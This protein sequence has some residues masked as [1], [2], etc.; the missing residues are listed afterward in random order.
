[1][2]QVIAAK[3]VGMSQGTYAELEKSGN[4]SSFTVSLAKAYG[5][6]PE[7]LE[8]GRGEMLTSN[9]EDGPSIRGDVPL[10]SWVQA[11]YG[12]SAVDNLQ[13]GEGERVETTYKVKRHTYALRVTGDS[14]E[15][16]FPRGCIVIVEPE[17]DPVTGKFVIVR[18]NGD[19][20]T[21][22][23]YVEEG[24]DKFLKPMNPRY[25]IEKMRPGDEFCGVVKRIEMDV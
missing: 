2:T 23:Q 21:L 18:R 3:T 20:P 11:G 4:G 7:W 19:E 14:M 13:P 10:I 6:N 1:M 15:P 9:V 5:V 12:K 25:P 22:K 8:T 16:N 24:G 17:D